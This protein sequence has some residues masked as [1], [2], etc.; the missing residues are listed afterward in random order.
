MICLAFLKETP[1][2]VQR[3]K[4]VYL[5]KSTGAWESG[6]ERKGLIDLFLCCENKDTYQ[7]GW[8]SDP[9]RFMHPH[10]DEIN[11]VY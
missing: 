4:A 1:W 2:I 11:F 5:L 7:P 8:L 10:L 3:L 9:N 6:S